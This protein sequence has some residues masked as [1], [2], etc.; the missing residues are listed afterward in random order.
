MRY[1]I[2]LSAGALVTLGLFYF[3]SVLISQGKKK[4]VENDLGPVVE[5]IR[6]NRNQ[7]TK[8]R[9]REFTEKASPSQSS[10]SKTKNASCGITISLRRISLICRSLGLLTG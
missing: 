8:T 3:M 1:L 6:V 10:S 7:D 9:S 2:A 4:P 5:F